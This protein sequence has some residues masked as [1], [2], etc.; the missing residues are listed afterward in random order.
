MTPQVKE[1]IAAMKAAG[2]SRKDFSCK[3]DRL[4]GGYGRAMITTFCPTSKVVERTDALLAA[5]FGVVHYVD[6]GDNRVIGTHITTDPRQVGRLRLRELESRHSLFSN[7][8]SGRQ[9]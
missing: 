2:F 7:E 6:E 8:N 1:A 5:G 4:S 9:R 3:V